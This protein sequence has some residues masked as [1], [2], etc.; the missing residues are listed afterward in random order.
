MT[1][2]AR[3]NVYRDAF[4]A[5]DLSGTLALFADQ[6]LFEMP[7]L[8]QRLVGKREIAT[9]LQ[10]IFALTESVKL[11]VSAAKE[12]PTLAIA[13]GLLQAKLYRDP[14]PAAIPLAV[15]IEVREAL[16]GRLSMYFDA[17]LHRLWSDGPL[18]PAAQPSGQA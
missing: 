1:M 3:L 18:F 16:I 7:L 4:N 6:A 14:H 15:V 9:G 8:G 5:R 10:R 13:E 11:Q 12:S 2:L 17:R